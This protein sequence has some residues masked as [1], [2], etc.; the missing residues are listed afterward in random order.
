MIFYRDLPAA[1]FDTETS[2][3]PFAMIAQ[4]QHSRPLLRLT[5]PI[6]DRNLLLVTGSAEVLGV[7][8]DPESFSSRGH[9]QANRFDSDFNPEAAVFFTNRG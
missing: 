4:H 7:I 2:C 5:S 8:G 9:S 3:C 6:F 1:D